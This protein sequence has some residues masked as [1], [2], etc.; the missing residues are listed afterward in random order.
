MITL[1]LMTG[2][3]LLASIIADREKTGRALLLAGRRFLK[4]LPAFLTMLCIV[5]LV[6]SFL[7]EEVFVRYLG[8]DNLFFTTAAASILGSI[9]LMPGFIAFPLSGLLRSQGVANIVLAAFTTTLMMVGILTFPIERYYLG[10]KVAIV[11]N[12]ISFVVAL[13]VAIVIGI[14]FGELW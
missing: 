2:A 6:L 8:R 12:L 3:A 5:A 11:R 1:Y 13:I 4:I 7:P 10:T 14:F 9:T